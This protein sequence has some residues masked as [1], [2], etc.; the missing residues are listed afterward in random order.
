MNHKIEHAVRAAGDA[1]F[2][3]LRLEQRL[4]VEKKQLAETRA[5]YHEAIAEYERLMVQVD[6][7]VREDAAADLADPRRGT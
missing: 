7:L 6:L 3:V 2:K 5:A 4:E 1:H